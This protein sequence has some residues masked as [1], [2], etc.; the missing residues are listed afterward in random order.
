MPPRRRGAPEEERAQGHKS[1]KGK[2]Q[3]VAAWEV[4][5]IK[6]R[7]RGE[8]APLGLEARLVG[9][10]EELAVLKQTLH[11]VEQEGRP[12]LVTVLGNAGVGK[13]RLAWEL[14][15]YADGLP[16][17]I[18]W[19]KGRCLAYGN[20]AYSALA[21]AVKAHCEVL[22]DDQPE[23]V[24]AKVDRAVA[25]LFEDLEVAPHVRTLVGAAADRTFSREDLFDAWRRFLERLAARYPLVLV[26]E[27]IHWADAGLLDF[28]D[29]L[30]DWAQGPIFV[31]TLARHELLELRPAWGGGKRNYAAIDLDPLTGDECRAMIDDLLATTL[32]PDL[33]SL[34]VERS[35]GNPLFTEEIVRMFI[36]RGVLRATEARWEVARPVEEVEVPRSIQGLIAARLDT[37]PSEEKALLQDAAVVGRVFWMG[38][39]A[40][41]SGRGSAEVREPLGRLRVKEIVVPREPPMFSG[42]LEFAFRHVL[43]RD[44]AYESL[45]KALRSAKHAEVAS[46]A[47]DRAGDRSEEIAELLATHYLESL[48]Y[49]EE[50]GETN[51]NR[52]ALQR[53]AFRWAKSAAERTLRLRLAGE[54]ARWY[55]SALDLAGRLGVGAG[56]MAGLWQAYAEACFGVEPWAETTRAWEHSLRLALE[57]GD[58]AGAG[59]AEAALLGMAFNAGDDEAV[60]AHAERALS[61]LEPLGDSVDLADALH[62]LGW[63]H[64]RRGQLDEAEGPLRRSEE[65]ARRVGG[66]G[67]VEVQRGGPRE[68]LDMIEEAFRI[69]K[70][71]GDLWLLLRNYNNL[72]ATMHS[73]A[74][75]PEREEAILREGL[76][77]ARKAGARDSQAWILGTLSELLTER[78]ELE[79]AERLGRKALQ[80]ARGIGNQVVVGMRLG[81][82]AVVQVF[83]GEDAEAEQSFQESTDIEA[84]N[85]EPQA[86]APLYLVEYTKCYLPEGENPDPKARP[87]EV[88]ENLS[89]KKLA[90]VPGGFFVDAYEA[91][92]STVADRSTRPRP[93]AREA[94]EPPQSGTIPIAPH[95]RRFRQAPGECPRVR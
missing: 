41:L 10:D 54:S 60:L 83:R 90:A 84:A 21:E 23:T 89:G 9:R 64:W 14:L 35:E 38:S 43:I 56:E 7:R 58:P 49:L 33:T 25:D 73:V 50:L 59:R 13:S 18:Y 76:E 87:F 4:L 95:P 22:E 36:D 34:I 65:M 6:A 40:R 17:R 81:S 66:R 37:L 55:R 8:R 91:F 86:R 20:L 11:R 48:R 62:W 67:I 69:A 68:G 45:P 46:W 47:E 85:P 57:A 52:A 30:A 82:L 28:V 32:P 51:G 72:P 15:K 88:T 70:D 1:A 80:L 12:S 92:P 29:H 74:P 39:V 3:P 5:R 16:Q 53:E 78:G 77:L 44:V 2:A 94:N 93:Q 19:R 31:L 24:G 61:Y 26:L 79:E 27:D 75:D 71:T 63:F 42:E